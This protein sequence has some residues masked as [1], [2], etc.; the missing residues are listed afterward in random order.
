MEDCRKNTMKCIKKL[1]KL[2]HVRPDPDDM[3]YNIAEATHGVNLGEEGW[4][5]FYNYIT[6][7]DTDDWEYQQKADLMTLGDIPTKDLAI[8]A[9]ELN[10]SYD[11][12]NQDFQV[13]HNGM[14]TIIQVTNKKV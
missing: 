1:E 8:M 2:N 14:E 12:C 6:L 9:E 11:E 13:T 7:Q 5:N 3:L 10:N 4:A